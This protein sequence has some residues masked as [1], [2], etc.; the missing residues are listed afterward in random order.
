MVAVNFAVPVVKEEP[1]CTNFGTEGNTPMVVAV[2][3][4]S[5]RRQARSTPSSKTLFATGRK[6]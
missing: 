2:P 5:G 1:V 4:L 3:A 6:K